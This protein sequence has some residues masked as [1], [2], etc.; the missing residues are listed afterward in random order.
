MSSREILRWQGSQRIETQPGSG[1]VMIACPFQ[2]VSLG[3]EQ[4]ED[5]SSPHVPDAKLPQPVIGTDSPAPPDPRAPSGPGTNMRAQRAADLELHV[6]RR[7]AV[8]RPVHVD[9]RI[10]RRPPFLGPR[11]SRGQLE[12]GV[13]HVGT[14]RISP[15]GPVM[16]DEG[17][18]VRVDLCNRDGRCDA[19]SDLI[20][21]TPQE[22]VAGSGKDDIGSREYLEPLRIHQSV[23][24]PEEQIPDP[25]AGLL[26][27]GV[28]IQ[29]EEGDIHPDET[30]VQDRL[31]D[32]ERGLILSP[33]TAP[34]PELVLEL[35]PSEEGRGVCPG[36][37]G[38]HI[39][40]LLP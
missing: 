14:A 31:I 29:P 33:R 26:A 21:A 40:H 34:I 17:K 10:E 5:R 32:A 16:L 13:I 2:A 4:T 35:N 19:R 22:S 23:A 30:A 39:Q 24:C 28:G 11:N 12:L 36:V 6:H 18:E 1:I 25:R 20:F 37:G 38:E 27:G 7:L 15:D 9:V 3:N 8:L